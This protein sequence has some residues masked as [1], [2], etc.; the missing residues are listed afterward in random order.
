MILVVSTQF[1]AEV[2]YL[3][4]NKICYKEFRAGQLL[5]IFLERAK[6]NLFIEK[7]CR[8]FIELNYADIYELLFIKP[9]RILTGLLRQIESLNENPIFS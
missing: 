4:Y 3:Q 9:L 2:S 6:E 8:I 5:F 7:L 1:S